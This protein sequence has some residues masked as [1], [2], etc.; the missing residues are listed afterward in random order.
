MKIQPPKTYTRFY[1]MEVAQ[2][3]EADNHLR[4]MNSDQMRPGGLLKCEST[5]TNSLVVALHLIAKAL[6]VEQK[7]HLFMHGNLRQ[8]FERL[9]RLEK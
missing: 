1:L 9:S 6:G 4:M 2:G 8:E 3:S 7:L 5:V